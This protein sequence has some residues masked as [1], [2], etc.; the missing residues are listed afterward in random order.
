MQLHLDSA[1][2]N[3]WKR[4][5][6]KSY[7]RLESHARNQNMHTLGESETENMWNTLVIYIMCIVH[8]LFVI[9][10]KIFEKSQVFTLI[11]DLYNYYSE[12]WI[13]SILCNVLV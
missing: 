4:W 9:L 2:V 1:S 5:N 10:T 13:L 12:F 11:P 8:F 6:L 7:P 3:H